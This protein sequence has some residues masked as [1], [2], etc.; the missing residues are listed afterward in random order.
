MVELKYRMI[1]EVKS[2]ELEVL[3]DKVIKDI[4]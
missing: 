2:G 4:W 3:K 1:L